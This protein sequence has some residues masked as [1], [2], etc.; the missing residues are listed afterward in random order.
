MD[1]K[2]WEDWHDQFEDDMRDYERATT[3]QGRNTALMCAASALMNLE[4]AINNMI[5][6]T[7]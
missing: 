6:L 5:D 7:D 1:D 3:D 4:V 2:T